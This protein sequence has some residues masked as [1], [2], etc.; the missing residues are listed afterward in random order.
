MVMSVTVDFSRRFYR[1]IKMIQKLYYKK[2]FNL[3]N[4][5]LKPTGLY[6]LSS[7]STFSINRRDWVPFNHYRG[8]LRIRFHSSLNR[9]KKFIL[10][11]TVFLI[12]K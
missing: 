9:G 8:S 12:L 6:P 4:M 2:W 5:Y 3:K 10:F 11:L 7:N 1:T